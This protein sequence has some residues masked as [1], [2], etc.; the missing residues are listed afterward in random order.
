MMLHLRERS[1]CGARPVGNSHSGTIQELES[2]FAW[3][4]P[5]AVFLIDQVQD[6]LIS[7]I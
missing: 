4:I 7:D 6:L 3:S 2:R 5:L 1:G